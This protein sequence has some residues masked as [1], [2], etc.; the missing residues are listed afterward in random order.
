MQSSTFKTT[1]VWSMVIRGTPSCSCIYRIMLID[2]VLVWGFNKATVQEEGPSH[3]AD[4]EWWVARRRLS[5]GIGVYLSLDLLFS[6]LSGRQ[7]RND[8]LT[9]IWLL[10]KDIC[11]LSLFWGAGGPFGSFVC[12]F[13]LGGSSSIWSRSIYPITERPGE[14]LHKAQ[15]SRHP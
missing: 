7:N 14:I 4:E 8:F 12:I 11:P 13:I 2:P 6:C 10:P 5:A 9:R 15:G 1:K 3:V